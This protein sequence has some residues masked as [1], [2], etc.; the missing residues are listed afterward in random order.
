MDDWIALNS[1]KI[2][3]DIIWRL[4]FKFA[5]S[6][7]KNDGWLE[8]FRKSWKFDNLASKFVIFLVKDLILVYSLDILL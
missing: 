6:L 8:L 1:G 4:S 5:T 2:L 7:L 3:E